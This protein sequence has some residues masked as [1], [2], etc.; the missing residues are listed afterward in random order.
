MRLV[1]R[2]SALA[3]ACCCLAPGF[4]SNPA[5]VANLTQA[6]AAR[7]E[8]S[9]VGA[10][11]SDNFDRAS[12]GTNWVI[13]SDANVSLVGTE[14]RFSETNA[15]LTRQVYFDP[16]LTSSDHW[17]LRWTQR[18]GATNNSSFG[19]GVGIR[20]FQAQ[21]GNDRG[22]NAVL[23]GAGTHY[24]QMGIERW[25]G[26][27]QNDITYGS[28]IPLAPGDLV[29]CWLTRSGW[30]L[31]A[32]ASNRANGQVSTTSLVF[33][34]FA[35][36]RLEAPTISRMCFYP[37]QGT[38]YVDNLS[39]SINRRKPARFVVIGDSI[40]EGYDATNYA[41]TYI[42]VVQSNF[43]QAVCNESSSY[44]TTDNAVSILP[45]ILALQ[46]ETAILMIGGNDLYFGNPTAQW[47]SNYSNLVAQ[48]QANGVNVKHCWPTPRTPVDLRPLKTWISANYPAQ[49]IIDTWT[50]LLT[51]SYKLK[52]A[53]DNYDNDGT[54]PNDAG[55]LVIG[56][57]I[58]T[59]LP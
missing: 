57:I 28:A 51:D 21:G 8:T 12:L 23:N 40:S 52:P 37:L 26:T 36:P 6:S 53:Y 13:V 27:Q 4:F 32:T 10:V 35:S 24:G 41:N 31:S 50:P 22:Y 55:H 5:R 59:N 30:T 56:Q 45:E 1:V 54:H 44:N 38:V 15:D 58:R 17:T 48:L 39:F 33:S 7:W 14:L 42:S 47:Q 3:L 18:F 9:E 43:T 20:N 29:D 34:D 19:V 2:S 46:P 16:W 49:D 25:D 11:W